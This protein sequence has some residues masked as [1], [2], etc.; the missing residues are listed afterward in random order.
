MSATTVTAVPTASVAVAET[1]TRTRPSLWRPGL[2]AGVVAAAVTSAVAAVALA[3]DVPL[4][5]GGEQI[6]VLAFAQMTLLGTVLGIVLAKAVSGWTARP[7]R[8]FVGV[9]VALTALS[10]VPDLTADA[11]TASK[12]VLMASHVVAAA[13]VVPAI[14]NRL[15]RHSDR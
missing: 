5:I 15:P 13:I 8:T 3:A 7:Q 2:L 6:P 10:L 14:A 11:T 9:T 4:E 12:A 1:D